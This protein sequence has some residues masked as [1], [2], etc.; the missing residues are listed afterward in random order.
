MNPYFG[1]VAG[2]LVAI[3]N[4]LLAFGTFLI[5]LPITR[6][7]LIASVAVLIASAL[8]LWAIAGV[9]WGRLAVTA[10]TVNLIVGLFCAIYAI[11]TA[12]TFNGSIRLTSL[13]ACLM[14]VPC[15]LTALALGKL[16]SESGVSVGAKIE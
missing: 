16:P 3:L 14:V 13:L 12:I 7:A 15:V 5:I 8:G 1:P 4:V 2:L 9:R 11:G 6:G 10:M